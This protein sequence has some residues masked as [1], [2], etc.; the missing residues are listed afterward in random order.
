MIRYAEFVLEEFSREKMVFIV[1]PRQVGK[2]T[3][4]QSWLGDKKGLYLN[5]D[6]SEDRHAILTKTFSSFDKHQDIVFDELHKYDRWKS[7]L[8]GIYDKH[9]K[10]LSIVVTGSARLDIYKRGGDSLLGR[11]ELIHLHPF[12]VGELTHG[13]ILPPPESWLEFDTI[14][15]ESSLW[16]HLE[17]RSGFPEP[18]TKD[19]TLHHRRWSNRRRDLLIKE[20]VRE[21]SQ[22]K[23]LSL[24]EHLAIL[25][26]PRV[27]SPLSV[28]SLR[29]ELQV[30]HDTVS[31]WLTTFEHLFYCFRISPYSKKIS[32]SLKKEQKLYLWD[33]SQIEDKASRFENMVALHLLKAIQTWT[34]LGY[35]EYSLHY[36]RNRQHQEVD[37]LIAER[38]KP[39]VIIEA[40]LSE[41]N[42]S[43]NLV[44]FSDQLGNIPMIQL[45]ST[46]NISKHKSNSWIVSADLFFTGLV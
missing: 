2:T 38:N 21:V 39:L 11:Y 13:K 18:F 29:E 42:L 5:W 43:P 3:M 8:K 41:Q 32:S 34:D 1:G 19:D 6:N 24:I 15:P 25:L 16:E 20:D 14:T 35:G 12:T 44:T 17:K 30:S 4:A 36:L 26:S 28:N 7:W 22:V 45:L 37:F 27:G 40:K 33:W 23:S 46:P 10:L 31:S 9:S